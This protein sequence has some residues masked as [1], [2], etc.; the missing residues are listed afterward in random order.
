[1]QGVIKDYSSYV[2]VG[3]TL[4]VLRLKELDHEVFL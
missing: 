1:L 4:Y 3:S 2:L